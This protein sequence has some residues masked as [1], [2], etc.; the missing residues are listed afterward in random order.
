M[1]PARWLA[2]LFAVG[3]SDGSTTNTTPDGSLVV[4]GAGGDAAGDDASEVPVDAPMP[5]GWTETQLDHPGLRAMWVAS[6]GDV[7]LGGSA[8]RHR[9][10]DGV[11][12]LEP[13]PFADHFE[14]VY[15]IWGSGPND[16][17]AVGTL[18]N[19]EH[20]TG[21][22]TWTQVPRFT[23]RN[24]RYLDGVWGSGPNDVY[25]GGMSSSQFGDVG[26]CV[27]HWNGSVWTDRTPP[28]PIGQVH[29]I[30]GTG[31]NDVWA[32]ASGAIVF[33]RDGTGTWTRYLDDDTHGTGEFTTIWGSSSSN[34]YVGG[35]DGGMVRWNGSSWQ[36]LP[37]LSQ[38]N[39][40]QL[41]GTSATNLYALTGD[42]LFH[43]TGGAFTEVL[44]TLGTSPPNGAA[45]YD[46]WGTSASNVLVSGG[47]GSSMYLVTGP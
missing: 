33:H 28:F 13:H 11:W 5:M 25:V 34:I 19:I 42:A 44:D 14:S 46:L 39:V 1:A 35:T 36:A 30:W 6:T 17:W 29:A 27:L 3:C 24:C 32:V 43:S 23:E 20:S 15:E 47:Y 2:L 10:P 26:P 16:I 7:Y 38:A 45:F 41:W 40:H 4:D 8:I 37:T 21:D 12:H 18:G 31:P 22:G 9:T